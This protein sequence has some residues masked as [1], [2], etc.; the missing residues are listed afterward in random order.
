MPT[1]IALGNSQTISVAFL[2]TGSARWI[3]RTRAEARLGIIADDTR[4][5]DLGLTQGWLAPNR[6]AAQTEAVVAPG[7]I[8][9]FSF[10]IYGRVSGTYNIPVG[11]LV[12]GVA[13][14][15]GATTSIDVVIH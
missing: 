8:A 1:V 2:N 6:P 10:A 12:D 15:D 9:T 4:F 5:T 11:L 7:A 13:W 14:V 3:R